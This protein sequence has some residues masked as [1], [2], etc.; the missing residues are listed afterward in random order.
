MKKIIILFGVI[1]LPLVL[2]CQYSF[3]TVISSDKSEVFKYAFETENNNY[4]AVGYCNHLSGTISIG[5]PLI[6]KVNE[7]HL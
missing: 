3:E 1:V 7:G 4:I 6:V 5:S 2:M